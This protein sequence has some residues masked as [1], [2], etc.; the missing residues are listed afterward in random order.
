MYFCPG[1][2]IVLEKEINS[3]GHDKY[4]FSGTMIESSSG[5]IQLM[6]VLIMQHSMNKN[7]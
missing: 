6:Q 7:Y 1:W 2:D 5:H 3:I 4:Y